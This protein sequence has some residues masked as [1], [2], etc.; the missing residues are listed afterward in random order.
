MGLIRSQ[1]V[2]CI[3]RVYRGK[4]HGDRTRVSYVGHEECTA[5][6]DQGICFCLRSCLFLLR[7]ITV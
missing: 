2:I 3:R 5:N 1:G 4:R 6:N 7:A